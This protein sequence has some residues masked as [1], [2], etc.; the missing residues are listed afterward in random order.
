MTSFISQLADTCSDLAGPFFIALPARI[1]GGALRYARRKP[2][3]TEKV[4]PEDIR[5]VLVVRL[6]GLGDV[7]LM[8]ALLRGLRRRF[9][10]A[11]I[12]LIVDERLRTFLE[13]CPWVDAVIGFHESPAKYKRVLLG[14]LHTWRF[15]AA[16]L[17]S[18][19]FD[20]AINPRWDIDSRAAAMVGYLSL[21]RFHIGFPES[22]TRR[23]GRLNRGVNHLF[24]HLVPCSPEPIHESERNREVLSA[25]GLE[26]DDLSP[27]VWL[28]ENDRYWA[29]R[30]MDEHNPDSANPVICIA[31]GAI[32]AKRKWPMDRFAQVTDWLVHELNARVI[33]IGDKGDQ[34][35]TARL[36]LN[37]S[38]GI[39]NLSGTCTLRQSAAILARCD[40]FIGNDSGPMHI[41][42]ALRIPVVEISCHPANGDPGHV[43][44]P[45]RYGP[46][47]V[48]NRILQPRA[49][50]QPC[51]HWCGWVLPHCILDIDVQSV[52]KAIGDLLPSRTRDPRPPEE[53]FAV[54][55]RSD[56]AH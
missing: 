26:T 7:V 39:V 52:K 31:T 16:N 20:L 2:L 38:R 13:L 11:K 15:A 4:N 54:S 23:K 49:P 12:T 47:D 19:N 51:R 1:A 50:R 6:D 14:A 17:H 43:N 33:M 46:R 24:S 21:A 25:L 40:L 42:R 5:S 35:E 55:S 34:I 36:S 30:I 53:S 41:A 44:S 9:P 45:I 18:E 37:P 32:E 48:P 8:S 3:S 22:V 27:E 29:R 10:A 56:R 28:G